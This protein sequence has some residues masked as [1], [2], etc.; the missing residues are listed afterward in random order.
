MNMDSNDAGRVNNRQSRG[1]EAH[2]LVTVV[3]KELAVP[4]QEAFDWIGRYHDGLVDRFLSLY[5]NSVPVFEDEKVN[6]EL[7]EYL[8]GVGNWVRCNESWSFEV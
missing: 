2:N 8:D 5:R 3:M 7:R 1:E 6:A 4:V